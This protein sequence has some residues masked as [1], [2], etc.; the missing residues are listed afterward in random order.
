MC[1]DIIL[2]KN[3]TASN[4]KFSLL[5]SVSIMQQSVSDTTDHDPLLGLPLKPTKRFTSDDCDDEPK[6][7]QISPAQLSSNKLARQDQIE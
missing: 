7:S 1:A 6:A 2:F 5:I 4:S 3:S